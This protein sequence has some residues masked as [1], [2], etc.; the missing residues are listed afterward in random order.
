VR[1]INNHIDNLNSL[2]TDFKKARK[3]QER[4]CAHLE[5]QQIQWYQRYHIEDKVARVNIVAGQLPVIVYLRD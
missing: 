3:T 5:L 4:M 2:I 1:Q